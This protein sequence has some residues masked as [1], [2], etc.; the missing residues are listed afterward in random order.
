MR[1][2][3]P[4]GARIKINDRPY[5]MVQSMMGLNHVVVLEVAPRWCLSLWLSKKGS[6]VGYQDL[7]SVGFLIFKG[8]HSHF[9]FKFDMLMLAVF[10][11]GE[12]VNEL[13]YAVPTSR[14]I[15]VLFSLG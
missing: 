3:C 14:V 10:V 12:R 4:S 9:T 7:R 13:F 6:L 11:A 1:E 2:L 15:R 5:L 8:R